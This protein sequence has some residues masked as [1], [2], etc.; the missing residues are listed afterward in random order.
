MAISRDGKRILIKRQQY[1]GTHNYT[2]SC[3]DFLTR[4]LLTSYTGQCSAL[5]FMP[6]GYDF[7]VGRDSGSVQLI[8]GDS[9]EAI[10]SFT[11][12]MGAVNSLQVFAN[13]ER[14]LTGSADGSA[15]IWNMATGYPVRTFPVSSPVKAVAASPSGLHV[16]TG[17]NDLRLWDAS[18]GSLL[19]RFAHGSVSAVGFTRDGRLF[20]TGGD[21]RAHL[22]N[23]PSNGVADSAWARYE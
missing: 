8:N 2:Y 14:L 12:H 13:G 22:W 20:S 21:G 17:A 16:L 18:S 4:Q 15:R 19:A 5:C 1:D 3:F 9:G 6:S 10:C 11:G 23:N 7:V